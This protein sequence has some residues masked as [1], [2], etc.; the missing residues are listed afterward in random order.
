[1]KKR[2]IATGKIQNK[3]A[4]FDYELSDEIIAGI[5]LTGREVKSLRQGH[6]FLRGSFVT[7]KGNQLLLTNATITSGKTFVIPEVEQTR[8]RVLLVS[9]KQFTQLVMAKQQGKTIVPIEFLTKGRFIKIKIAVGKGKKR[10]DKRQ[11]IKA[12]DQRIELSRSMVTR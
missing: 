5:S 7:I 10:Y 4:K 1:M 2:S 11:S 8:S 3:R 9:K 12:R 6:A